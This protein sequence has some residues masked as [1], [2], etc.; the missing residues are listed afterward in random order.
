[1]SIATAPLAAMSATSRVVAA[2]RWRDHDAV[3]AS[4]GHLTLD[5]VAARSS[6]VANAKI[7]SQPAELGEQ[8]R[9]RRWRDSSLAMLAHLR[10]LALLCY[11]NGNLSLNVKAHIFH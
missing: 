6:F 11:R 7:D 1:M 5:A 2:W 4:G 3:M 8:L 10:A 9:H